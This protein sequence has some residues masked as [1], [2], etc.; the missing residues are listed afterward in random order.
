MQ[1]DSSPKSGRLRIADFE[2]D[3]QSHE[4]L[5]FGRRVR[6]QEKSFL[7]LNELLRRPGQVVTREELAEALWPQDHFVDAEHGLN[8]AV[9]RLREALG[10]S[11][12]EPCFVETLPKVGYRLIAEVERVESSERPADASAHGGAAL[13]AA[14]EIEAAPRRRPWILVTAAAILALAAV[15]AA[16]LAVR[17]NARRA[18]APEPQQA[19]RADPVEELLARARYLRNHKRLGEAKTFIEEALKLEPNNPEALAGLAMTL[20]REG[21]FEQAR[22]TARRALELEPNTCEA[23]RLLGNLAHRAGDYVG[24]ERSFRRAVEANPADSKSRNRLAR[25]L[26]ESGRLEEAREQM[27]ESRRLAPDDPDV[28]NIWI[29]YALLTADYESA[30]RE[31]EIWMR[32]WERQLPS[33]N[34]AGVRYLLGL[35]YVGARRFEDAISFYRAQYPDDDLYVALALGHAGRLAEAR[36]ILDAPP[37][38]EVTAGSREAAELAEAAAMAWIASGDFDRAFEQL[39]RQL[40]ARHYPAWLHLPLFRSIRGDP[41]WPAFAER[42]ERE[43]FSGKE[44][45]LPSGPDGIHIWPLRIPAPAERAG[46]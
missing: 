44:D 3:L 31:A 43:F 36:A 39:D 40:E 10:D 9:R 35:A 24:A 14:A 12:E 30:I 1:I 29:H 28:Q 42:L 37:A 45:V 4:I 32:I 27:L 26:L 20:M 38:T 22:E 11:A 6:L 15:L 19:E 13:P 21:E 7:V 17:S 8:S 16:T 33:E 46:S 25:H 34:V 41:H 2:V 5:R 23:H 18:P